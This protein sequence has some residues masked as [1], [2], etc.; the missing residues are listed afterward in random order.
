MKRTK[1]QM[2]FQALTAWAKNK[3]WGL[4]DMATG[5]GKSKCGIDAA[6]AVAQAKLD[7]DAYIVL[8]VPTRKLK[9]RR[10]PD[11]FVK[12]D[13]KDLWDNHVD[14]ICYAS[15]HKIKNKVID[16]LIMDEGHN[17]TSR[18]ASIFKNNTVKKLLVLTATAPDSKSTASDR[19]KEDLFKRLN[20]NTVFTLTLEEALNE[21]LVAEFSI[22]VIECTLDD[23]VKYIKAGSK[24]KPFYQTEKAAYQYKNKVLNRLLWQGEDSQAVRNARAAL[25]KTF[26]SKQE[27]AKLI[28]NLHIKENERYIVYCGSIEQAENILPERTYHSKTN[29]KA[30]NAFL[31]KE[32][33][34]LAAVDALNEG[35]DIEEISGVIIVQLSSNKRDLIQRIGRALRLRHGHHAIIWILVIMDTVDEEWFRKAIAGINPSRITYYHWKN[36]KNFPTF[37]TPNNKCLTTN[38][39]L[40]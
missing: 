8:M 6:Y 38:Y 32:I 18:S 37:K 22:R 33:D 39:S 29:D 20:I 19:I 31:N 28:L 34:W 23:K 30:Y 25:V 36:I 5:S 13:K 3:C 21:G 26:K 14:R 17:L 24:A 12:W 4:L 9:N 15:G 35:E 2:Q 16:L 10:W 11:E 27:V 7:G 40:H 1:A